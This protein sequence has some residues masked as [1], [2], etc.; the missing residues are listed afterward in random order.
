MTPAQAGYSRRSRLDKLGVKDGAKVV[1]VG[2][3][4]AEFRRELRTRTGKVSIGRAGKG[5]DLVFF[6]VTGV[7]ELKR[8][9]VFREAIRP[10]GAI[11]VLWP[12]G[13][14]ALR[15]DDVRNAALSSG[16]VDIKVV[17]FSEALSGLKLVIPVAQR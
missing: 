9:K 3:S 14:P 15:E 10:A 17:A 16:L 1:L 5:N 7:S 6:S 8:L 13:R 11:W 4:D 2:L 12:K